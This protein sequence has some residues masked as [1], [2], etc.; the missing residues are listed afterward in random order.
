[1]CKYDSFQG[2][3][4]LT[5]F[6]GTTELSGCLCVNKSRR[7]RWA[8]HVVHMGE[9]EGIYVIGGKTKKRP[10]ERQRRRW[11]DNI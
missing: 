8:G 6:S 4:F 7:L 11:V 10:L 5:H 9:Q 1:M 2:P 3:I